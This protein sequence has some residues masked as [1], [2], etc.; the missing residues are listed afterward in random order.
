MTPEEALRVKSLT[1]RSD[2][3]NHVVEHL[4]K[5]G[6][7]SLTE[8]QTCAYRGANGTMCAV[9]AIMADDEYEPSFESRSIDQLVEENRLTPSFKE[10]IESN[11]DM[12]SD[13]QYFHDHYLEYWDGRF[14]EDAEARINKFAAKWKIK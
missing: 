10:R 13:L 6:T 4:R 11:L 12:L 14:T 3:F 5:Q 7:R 1:N 2:V 8:D 9:G